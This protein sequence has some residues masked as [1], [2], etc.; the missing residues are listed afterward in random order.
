MTITITIGLMRRRVMRRLVPGHSQGF[1]LR[2]AL[3]SPDASVFK[4]THYSCARLTGVPLS[5]NKSVLSSL[6][7]AGSLVTDSSYV[8]C[9]PKQGAKA[10][11]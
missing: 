3:L 8:A 7:T 2:L 11:R 4:W 6:L 9:T 5:S 10:V 1:H